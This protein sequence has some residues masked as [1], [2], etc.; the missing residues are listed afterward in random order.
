LRS[1]RSWSGHEQDN[2]FINL[3][4]GTFTD[5]SYVS[6]L[7]FTDDGRGMGSVDWDGDGDLDLILNNRT[8][9]RVRVMRNEYD[10]A[11]G[12]VAVN[13]VGTEGN[14][15]AIGA[16]VELR[17]S[18]RSLIGAVRASNNYVVQGSRWVH[19]G[20]GQ[21][22]EIRG[23]SV[24]WPNGSTEPISGVRPGMR[25][26]VVQGTGRAV[27]L[28]SPAGGFESLR[29]SDPG[30]P[31][32]SD[33]A[34]VTL[35]AR[36]PVPDLPITDFEGRSHVLSKMKG[37][38][39]LI[40]FWASWCPGCIEEL[41]G[42]VKDREALETSGVQI[43]AL[44]VDEASDRAAAVA[45]AREL[46][47]WF[48]A[49]MSDERAVSF[50]QAVRRE[51]LERH[52]DP[53]LPSSMLLDPKGR[54]TRMYLGPV[55]SRQVASD[56]TRLMSETEEAHYRVATL[57]GPGIWQIP[58]LIEKP[59]GFNRLYGLANQ[60]I[61]SG[62]YE[63]AYFFASRIGGSL[64][65][66]QVSAT[67]VSK[68]LS[69]MLTVAERLK[70]SAPEKA[71][72]LYRAVSRETPDDAAVLIE[73][74]GALASMGTPEALKE[75]AEVFD[76]ALIWLPA[77]VDADQWVAR[78]SMLGRLGRW[79]EAMPYFR[80]ALEVD[81]NHA[82]A[83]ARLGY[84][85]IQLGQTE[86][87]V[88]QL[89]EALKKAPPSASYELSLARALDSLSRGDEAIAHLKRFV[90]L[91]PK[92]E[93]AADRAALGG[94]MFRLNRMDEAVPHLQAAL[95]DNQDPEIRWQLGLALLQL[96]RDA[97]AL[98]HME[99]SIDAA[100]P[101]A[102][103]QYYY[104]MALARA[105][106]MEEAV[107][108]FEKAVALKDDHLDALLS[109]GIA[110][111]FL[112]RSGD[113]VERYRQY[114]RAKP[115]DLS[116][117]AKLGFAQQSLGAAKDAVDTYKQ[118]LEREPANTM[119]KFHLAWIYATAPDERVRDGQRA[120]QLAEEIAPTAPPGH[121]SML[122]LL[123]AVYAE[124]GR[125]DLAVQ[126]ATSAVDSAKTGGDDAFA[127]QIQTR[128]DL[129]KK[130]IAFRTPPPEGK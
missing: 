10:G 114:L 26:R 38:P 13:L 14:R 9:P 86:A 81:A 28:E 4:N 127:R 116:V 30:H 65:E 73:L 36:P 125:F 82:G 128:L 74:S 2:C 104:G 101:V 70:E 102:S 98:P 37:R 68:A 45:K 83:A 97:E 103:N 96:G 55:S 50:L 69:A 80:R 106:R 113:A 123:G 22:S 63:D 3:G 88:A 43:L 27:A 5:M 49:G 105:G 91:T 124:A 99:R 119:A 122:D 34:I 126:M 87:G 53:P 18:D 48:P 66:E 46:G 79:N 110:L 32:H 54:L 61:L 51:V 16:R 35:A 7:G 39:I 118:I 94:A 89:D 85:L 21:G 130:N 17:T 120:V 67:F 115:D 58:Q 92:P 20:L 44:S 8:S 31:E 62:E 12:W 77:P 47:L 129:Y 75:A 71:V 76:N 84:A 42:F 19:F 56:A 59:M 93:S 40:N 15:D 6:G 95:Q 11:N 60:L 90:E 1:G 23:L 111:D 33:K 117:M 64:A 72:E 121:P 24:R 57:N 52:D 78:G 41:T 108:R 29:P 109:L 107:G 112:G 25:Y 100:P